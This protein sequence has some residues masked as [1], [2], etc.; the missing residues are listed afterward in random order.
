MIVPEWL[1]TRSNADVE[2]AMPYRETLAHKLSS[3][4]RSF[5]D[6]KAEIERGVLVDQNARTLVR[7]VKLMHSIEALLVRTFGRIAASNLLYEMGK[8]AGR[9]FVYNVGKEVNRASGMQRFQKA[10]DNF[11]PLWGWEKLESKDFNVEKRIVSSRGE[12]SL[13]VRNKTGKAPTCH[14]NRGALAGTLEVILQ[15]DC[16]SIETA[17]QGK[18]DDY[19]EVITGASREIARIAEDLG[20]LPAP[21]L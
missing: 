3:L 20:R 18:G 7:P 11:A 16:E 5:H 17:C 21:R 14:F 1:R 15:S 10:C 19:C 9:H 13:F 2:E 8:E 4:E 6:L 12:G